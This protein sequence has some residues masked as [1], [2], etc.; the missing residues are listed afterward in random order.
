[1][2]GHGNIAHEKLLR[3][4][5]LR[6][7]ERARSELPQATESPSVCDRPQPDTI[8]F[9]T[10]RGLASISLFGFFLA[11]AGTVWGDRFSHERLPTDVHWSGAGQYFS[12]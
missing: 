1:V 12:C 2:V 5:H 8:L 7:Y 3:R 11:Q 6:V 10:F 9:W 4:Y